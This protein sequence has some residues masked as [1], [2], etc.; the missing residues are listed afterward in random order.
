MELVLASKSPQ[1]QKL[2]K[3]LQPHFLV[4]TS[5]INEQDIC[6][7][8]PQDTAFLRAVAKAQNVAHTFLQQNKLDYFVLGY[9][10]VMELDGKL[11]DKPKN[12]KQAIQML[13]SLSGCKHNV[14]TGVCLLAVNA[15]TDQ[16]VGDVCKTKVYFGSIPPKEIKEYCLTQEP[17]DKAGGYA[18]QGWAA[19]YISRIEGCYYNVMGLPVFLTH[20]LL[21]K[22]GF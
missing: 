9:D 15:K 2:L 18:I 8:I 17:Y 22:A 1:R 3:L 5:T 16:L 21:N 13:T 7:G 4:E 11:L 10:T 14:Y 20:E 12:Q 6:A 19:R